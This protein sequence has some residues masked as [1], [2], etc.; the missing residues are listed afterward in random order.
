[1]SVKKFRSVDHMP[2]P[3][4]LDPLDPDNFVRFFEVIA[5]AEQLCPFTRYEP[6]IKKFRSAEQ[7]FMSREQIRQIRGQP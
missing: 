6:G 2:G 1:M 7:A 5:L 4:P 3:P